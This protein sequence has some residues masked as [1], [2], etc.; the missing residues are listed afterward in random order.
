MPC[1]PAIPASVPGG[2]FQTPRVASVRAYTPAMTPHGARVR[3]FILLSGSD[4]RRRGK[5]AA[6]FSS[7][8]F[9]PDDFQSVAVS[10]S[11]T[12]GDA[13]IKRKA[14]R[15]LQYVTAALKIELGSTLESS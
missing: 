3:N 1:T 14:R 5:Y 8:T 13:S 2:A 10:T 6:A 9:K 4:K 11:L 15:V 12:S 7:C